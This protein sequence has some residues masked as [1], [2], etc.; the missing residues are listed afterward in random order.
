MVKRVSSL[1]GMYSTAPESNSGELYT[2][3]LRDLRLVCGCLAMETHFMKL[4]TNSYCADVASTDRLERAIF[5]G[6]VL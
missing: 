5:F 1:Q 2:I 6:P 4:P 3:A